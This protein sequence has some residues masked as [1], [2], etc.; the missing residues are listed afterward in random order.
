MQELYT[1]KEVA[2][3]MKISY[4]KVLDLIKNGD[5]SAIQVPGGYRVQ[6]EDLVKYYE[7]NGVNIDNT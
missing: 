4:R 2:D 3:M 6:Y 5:L 1:P 7:K